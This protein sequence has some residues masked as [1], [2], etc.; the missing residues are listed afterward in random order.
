MTQETHLTRRHFLETAALAATAATTATA[1]AADDKAQTGKQSKLKIGCLSWNFHSFDPGADCEK[2][3]D[4]IGEMGFEGIEL[5]INHPKDI[6][7]YWTD[8]RVARIKKKLDKYKLQVSQFVLF[9]PVVGGL[10]SLKADIRD[11]N[12]DNFSAGCKIAKKLEAPFINFVAP[13]SFDLKGPHGYLPRYY[14]IPKPKEA[15]KFH[16]DIAANFDWNQTWNTFTQTI[17]S[18]V[19]RAKD[20]GLKLT[21]EHHT[22]TLVPETAAFLRLW[23]SVRDPALGYTLDTGWTLLQREYPPLAMHKIKDHLLNIQVRDIDGMMR[24]FIPVGDGVMDIKAVVET[25][26]RIGYSGFLSIEQ[27]GGS[28]FDMKEVCKR[29]L[30]MM[31]EYIG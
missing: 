23:E 4:I 12:L 28:G 18:C 27:D 21:I 16:I 5:I 6:K 26:K 31:R 3:I 25:A 9:Q 24:R 8:E 11:Q 2:A 30:Q 17:K 7:D 13:W 14:D 29:Y 19:Q 15:E 10:S 20:H 1:S 22:H